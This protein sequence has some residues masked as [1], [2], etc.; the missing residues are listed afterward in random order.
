ML[1]T[2]AAFVNESS[3]I[4]GLVRYMPRDA[5]KSEGYYR[6]LVH[7]I[8]VDV[9]ILSYC[10]LLIF[11]L[12]VNSNARKVFMWAENALLKSRRRSILFILTIF[13]GVTVWVG[14]VAL[15]QF[16]NSADE[17]AYLFQAEDMSQGKFWSAAHELPEFFE[18]HHLL[19]KDGKWI[20]R[21]P[22]G[23]PLVLSV[24][25]ILHLPPFL[26]NVVLGLLFLFFFYRFAKEV[27][28]ERIAM[29][30]LIIMA[31]TGFFIFNAASFFSHVMSGL[32]SLLC[33]WMLYRY[34]GTQRIM[35]GFLAG[36]FLG[37]VVITRYYTAM[38][39]IFP[40]VVYTVYK[41]R[42]KSLGLFAW[43]TAG[44][45][46]PIAFLLWYNFSTTGDPF[47]LVT[48][49]GFDDEALGFVRGHTPGKGLKFTLKRL[50][51]FIHWCSPQ[52][53]LLYMFYIIQKV[54]KLKDAVDHP[55]DYLFIVL[56]VGYFFYY[57]SGGNQYGPRF[58]FEALPFL[59]VFVV[60]RVFN[61]GA[62][63][64]LALLISAIIFQ[65][66][67]IPFISA[68]ENA[69]VMERQ[70]VYAQVEK[71]G[72]VNA[73]IFIASDASVLRPMPPE[74]LNRNDKL[75]QNDVLYARDLGDKNAILVKYY[76]SRKFYKYVR[77]EDHAHG[78]LQPLELQ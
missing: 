58:Y 53:L 70:D 52:L 4:D 61:S 49:W 77:K 13:T 38:L 44:G 2:V 25:Y 19:Q 26:I 63:F 41:L 29:W 76:P 27:Y 56:I 14:A 42:A 37:M 45:I 66:V 3:I 12:L 48:Q 18:F 75:Y 21:F 54:R 20:G 30:A 9:A 73:I 40:F 24:G 50:V 35:A 68:H 65:W 51:M 17:Y 11:F 23:Y 59:V 8:I 46:L 43:M 62:K 78:Q 10:I 1:L 47:K 39:V 22:P 71:Q 60:V 31:F 74:D 57:H 33:V 5:G 34:F 67:K 55:E 6:D 28:N 36:L 32:F 69:V 15:D 72:I 7:L 16:P 64:P